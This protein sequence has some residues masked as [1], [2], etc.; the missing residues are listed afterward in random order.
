MKNRDLE[1]TW[2]YHNQTKHSYESVHSSPHFLDWENQPL[3]FKVYTSVDPLP[4]PQGFSPSSLKALSAL[5]S[6]G[7]EGACL[8]NLTALAQIFYFSAGVLRRRA[9]PGGAIYFRAAACTGA[10]YHIDL[11]LVCGDLAGLEAGVYHF[12]PHDF[13]LRRL[14]KGDYRAVLVAAGG[15]E[16]SLA[17]APAIL[18]GTSTYW[19]NAWK[20]RARTYRHCF[21]DSGTLLANL[22]ALA[23]AHRVPVR[24]VCGFV[25]AEVNRLLDIDAEHEAALF[26]VSLGR[27]PSEKPPPAPEIPPLFLETRP[28][29]RQEV[30]YPAI[31][32]MHAAS[33]LE[34]AE[35]VRA[36]REA[37][38]LLPRPKPRGPLFPL[39]PLTEPEY[40]QEPIEAV[41]LRRGSTRRFAHGSLSFSQLSTLL[42]R[43]TTA[44][45]C[46]FLASPNL[47]LNDLYLAVHCVDGLPPGLYV[48][49]RDRQ[50]LELLREGHFRKEAGYL[51][52]WQD[53]AADASVDVF[54]LAN[55]HP[56]LDRFGNR[57][58]RLA[59]LE[60]GTMGGKLYLAAYAQKLGATGLTFFDDEVTAFFSPH[61]QDKSA[62]FLVA[63]GK[64]ASFGRSSGERLS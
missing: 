38:F 17:Q 63:V 25:D 47:W 31:R 50:A 35:E 34:G 27:A 12:G 15:E 1:A 7:A 45:P 37:P 44:V 16:P 40:P 22:L 10:L 56:I 42:E 11:Y 9:Y 48:L 62:M 64:P 20:Y 28:L 8:P 24:V 32:A 58:Y 36:W 57:G 30:D 61:A 52:L 41:I 2:A 33:S 59:Q 13:A 39:R 43:A 51:A 53:L 29:S 18:V 14:R 4:L 23:S 21:W 5:S 6:Q 60:A 3:P 55:L 54:F 49:H 26:L 46:D 19:R